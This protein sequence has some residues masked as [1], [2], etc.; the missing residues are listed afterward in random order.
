LSGAASGQSERPFLD[1]LL[2]MVVSGIAN[3][4][5]HGFR[6]SQAACADWLFARFCRRRGFEM[7]YL[8]HSTMA[9]A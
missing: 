6:L 7:R 2:I 1:L 3:V 4:L 5:A 9:A 8:I